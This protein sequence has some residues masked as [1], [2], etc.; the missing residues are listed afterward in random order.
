MSP[1]VQTLP[2]LLYHQMGSYRV[3]AAAVTA[4]LLLTLTLALFFAI[5]RGIGG[6]AD[7]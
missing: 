1:G 3:E 5:E 4:L 6:R 7:D 2:L